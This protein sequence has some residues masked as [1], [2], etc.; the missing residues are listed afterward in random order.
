MIF[1]KFQS[2]THKIDTMVIRDIKREMPLK[3]WSFKVAEWIARIGTIGFVLTFITY[4]GFGLMMQ[5]YGQ[6]LPESFT[7]GCAQAIV[8]LIAIALVGFLV[9]GGLYVDLEKRGKRIKWLILPLHESETD[10][11]LIGLSG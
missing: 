8:A 10:R 3:Y 2:L 1:A 5:Y 4:F 6:N 7:E 9:R 11:H